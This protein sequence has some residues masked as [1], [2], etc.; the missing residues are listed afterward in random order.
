MT[1]RTLFLPFLILAAVAAGACQRD[2]AEPPVSTAP[3]PADTADQTLYH[4]RTLLTDAGL[5][6]AELLADTAYA[7]EEATRFEMRGVKT[8]FFT[9][10]GARDAVLTSKQ[11]TYNTRLG[12]MQARGDVV[13]VSED[14]RRLTT[15]ELRYDQARNEIASDS[16]FVATDPQHRLEGIGFRSDPNMINVRCLNACRG[17]AG[18]VNV[19]A[20]GASSGA[21]GAPVPAVAAP[22]DSA[23]LRP[24]SR[25]NTFKLPGQG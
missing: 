5:M 13:V 24:G 1:A 2:G 17:S 7:F 20:G 21:P 16:S 23:G 14:G 11:G 9:K 3:S 10:V 22:R 18:T 15:P 19:P 4:V 12:N 25:P 8:T 6:R